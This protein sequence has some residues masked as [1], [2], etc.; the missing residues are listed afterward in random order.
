MTDKIIA[1]CG[2]TCSE[3]D[4]Y[5]V[6]QSN[7][8]EKANKMAEEASKNL[9]VEMSV[10]QLWCDGCLGEGRKCGYC[11]QCAIRKCAS[12]KKVANCAH[13]GDY[14]CETLTSFIKNVPK[15]RETLD[16]IKSAL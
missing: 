1:Y 12:V 5:V 8:M 11:H 13:C 14:P 15:A 6:T 7:D 16:S 9:G 2:I 10:E 4:A 3:C